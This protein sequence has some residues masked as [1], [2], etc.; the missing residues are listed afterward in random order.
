[1][2]QQPDSLASW[3]DRALRA[4]ADLRALRTQRSVRVAPTQRQGKL[5]AVIR[6]YIAEHGIAPTVVEMRQRMGVRSTQGIH[7]MLVALEDRGQIRRIRRRAR[8]IEL[9]DGGA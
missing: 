9:L 7:R 4:E 5:L 8:A 1:M 3:R 2:S 6:A